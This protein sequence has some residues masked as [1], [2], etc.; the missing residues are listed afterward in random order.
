M[1]DKGDGF[2]IDLD[3]EVSVTEFE[4]YTQAVSTVQKK[5]R[6]RPLSDG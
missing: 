4:V 2:L 5:K 3:N 6:P 1:T